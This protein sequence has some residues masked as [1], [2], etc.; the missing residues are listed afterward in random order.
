MGRLS[1]VYGQA[2]SF[3][4]VAFAVRRVFFQYGAIKRYA[5]NKG[6]TYLFIMNR[7]HLPPNMRYTADM[8]VLCITKAHGVAKRDR[9]AIWHYDAGGHGC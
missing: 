9:R 4:V 6:A 3:W 1:T 7:L 5:D 8:V 2:G